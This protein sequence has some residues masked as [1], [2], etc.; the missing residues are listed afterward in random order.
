MLDSNLSGLLVLVTSAN[1]PCIHQEYLHVGGFQ[2]LPETIA[3]L[4]M[5]EGKERI[6]SRNSQEFAGFGCAPG[7][8][9]AGFA[10]HEVSGGLMTVE[11]SDTGYDVV[12][13][14]QDQEE[15]G[16]L[17]TS[18]VHVSGDVLHSDNGPAV[19]SVAGVIKIQVALVVLRHI[20]EIRIR[21]RDCAM[22]G[23]LI[24]RVQTK[25]FGKT[26]VFSRV[27][28][29]PG[30]Q[31]DEVVLNRRGVVLLG[32]RSCGLACSGQPDDQTHPI[33]VTN[34][35]NFAAGVERKP[36]A[37]INDLVPHAEAALLGLPKIITV[38]NSC[39]AFSEVDSDQ[40][41]GR[42][43]WHSK[44]RRIDDCKPRLE[45]APF[46]TGYRVI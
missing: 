15:I 30:H 27:Y 22:N 4:G 10:Q 2:Q 31:R 34:R 46:F 38:E 17:D 8:S 39:D 45:V 41:V 19:L 1:A 40:A 21:G 44:V 29:A 36:A 11:L 14:I 9:A 37:I 43:S 28:F 13:A 24:V 20:L 26:A 16:R 6:R 32:K 18:G 25:S 5:L 42:I 12:I 35:Y 7:G 23:G 33:A 3:L